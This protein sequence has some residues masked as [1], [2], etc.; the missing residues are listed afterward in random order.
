MYFSLLFTILVTVPGYQSEKIPELLPLTT[1]TGDEDAPRFSPDG[2][3]L[4][5]QYS[6]NRST[7]L[8]K[9]DLKSNHIEQLTDSGTYNAFATWSSDGAS[10]FY[11]SNQDGKTGFWSMDLRNK[12]TQKLTIPLQSLDYAYGIDCN[13]HDGTFLFNGI[14]QGQSF[15]FAWQKEMEIPQKITTNGDEFAPRWTKNGHQLVYHTGQQD[16]IRII[17]WKTKNVK[18]LEGIRGWHP[19]LS[20]DGNWVLYISEDTLSGCYNTWLT[21]VNNVKNTKQLTFGGADSYADWSPDGKQIALA[22]NPTNNQLYRVDIQTNRVEQITN[23]A[24][25]NRFY[26]LQNEELAFI[27]T[28][29]LRIKNIQTNVIKKLTD[30]PI[31]LVIQPQWS[32][33]GK[34]IALLR[35]ER[36][37]YQQGFSKSIWIISTTGD[38]TF[39]IK[40]PGSVEYFIWAKDGKS[41]IISSQEEKGKAPQLWQASL[42]HNQATRLSNLPHAIFP[43]DITISGDTILCWSPQNGNNYLGQWLVETQQFQPIQSIQGVFPSWSPDGKTIAFFKKINGKDYLYVHDIAN[44]NSRQLLQTSVLPGKLDWKIDADAS[45]LYYNNVP[46]NFGIYL[47]EIEPYLK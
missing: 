47:L 41:L 32:P 11:N 9:I 43:S 2:K 10:V 40:H 31:S 45:W 21:E 16:T 29:N 22:R 5:F 18:T 26:I 1:L 39:Q 33:D 46:G 25:H 20:P 12:L 23:E 34:H 8:Y 27:S 30:Y 44:N 4:L 3:S 24:A 37:D 15:V 35:G 7:H 36:L 28:D 13:L 6:E 38:T 19:T 17:D 14:K 42:L